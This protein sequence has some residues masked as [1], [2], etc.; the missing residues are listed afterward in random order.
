[1]DNFVAIDFETAN[2]KRASV[3]EAGICIV[4]NGKIAGTQSWLIDERGHA[5][6][7]NF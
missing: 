7:T 2:N 6:R 3:C 5:R 1:M 4:R